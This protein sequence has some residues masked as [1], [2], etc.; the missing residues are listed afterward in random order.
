MVSTQP[1]RTSAGRCWCRLFKTELVD[2]D[3]AAMNPVSAFTRFVCWPQGPQSYLAAIRF[4][5]A[6]VIGA[7]ILADWGFIDK[8]SHYQRQPKDADGYSVNFLFRP[9]D[10]IN[11]STLL[12]LV[13]LFLA[14][15]IKDDKETM[16][17]RD[18]RFFLV[19]WNALLLVLP[20]TAAGYIF[21]YHE[22]R[23]S[24]SGDAAFEATINAAFVS[25]CLELLWGAWPVHVSDLALPVLAGV[26]FLMYTFVLSK[27]F[28]TTL[29]S[30]LDWTGD[31]KVAMGNAAVF[32]AV[33]AGSALGC[34][35]VAWVRNRVCKSKAT[36][37]HSRYEM[38]PSNGV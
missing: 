23:Y 8:L 36:A 16:S 5:Q 14:S 7:S 30:E 29:Y 24:R 32:M 10:W 38:V 31:S 12:L 26:L 27:A 11:F 13:G 34:F 19:L 22:L 35:L 20:L 28:D 4:L 21:F 33:L 3:G 9:H 6:A 17:P 2:A 25:N 37:K 18:A 1:K 15:G